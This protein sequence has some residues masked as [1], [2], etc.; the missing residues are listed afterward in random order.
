MVDASSCNETNL[1]PKSPPQPAIQFT[2]E[3]EEAQLDVRAPV[4]YFCKRD[5]DDPNSIEGAFI[6]VRSYTPICYHHHG[7]FY[8]AVAS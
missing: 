2:P 8:I 7:I 1:Q 4:C 6:R 5:R 3:Q